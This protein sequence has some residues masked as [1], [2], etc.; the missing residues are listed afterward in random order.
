[1]MD[2][3]RVEFE[4]GKRYLANIMGWDPSNI[5]Q[6]D[7]DCAIEYLFPSGLTDLKARPV[8]KPPEE[9]LPKF[10]KFEFDKEGKPKNSLF[11]TLKPKFY[12][13][14]S[15]CVFLNYFHVFELSGNWTKDSVS[16]SSSR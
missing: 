16:Y 13:L 8:M 4:R 3:E 1:M 12:A 2:K 10:H 9:I 5:T 14:L 6:N 7:I 15:V 11:F